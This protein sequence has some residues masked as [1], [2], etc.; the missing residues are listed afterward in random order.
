[1]VT[2]LGGEM[3]TNIEKIIHLDLNNLPDHLDM[4][5]L[6]DI[7][8]ICLNGE[9]FKRDKPKEIKLTYLTYFQK[10]IVNCEPEINKPVFVLSG[11]GT[12]KTFALNERAKI[13]NFLYYHRYPDVIKRN[14]LSVENISIGY[15]YEDY[16]EIVFEMAHDVELILELIDRMKVIVF[17][18]GVDFFDKFAN[19]LKGEYIIISGFNVEDNPYSTPEYRGNLKSLT[20]KNRKRLYEGSFL[21]NKEKI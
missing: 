2:N 10:L 3:A 1:M 13:K 9:Y 19:R 12:G 4:N 8:S 21:N 20:Q 16:E 14:N 7:D 15:I 11:A 18:N 17:T 6:P 5:H